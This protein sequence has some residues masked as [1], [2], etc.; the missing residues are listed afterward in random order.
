MALESSEEAFGAASTSGAAFLEKIA[1][2]TATTAGASDD[3]LPIANHLCEGSLMDQTPSASFLGNNQ[4]SQV[5]QDGISSTRQNYLIVFNK[6]DL[7]LFLLQAKEGLPVPCAHLAGGGG[8]AHCRDG[9]QGLD[10]GPRRG[11]GQGGGDEEG[12]GEVEEDEC[13]GEGGVEGEGQGGRQGG[14]GQGGRQHQPEVKA[15]LGWTPKSETSLP[16]FPL[17]LKPVQC[18]V[19]KYVLVFLI[20]VPIFVPIFDPIDSINVLPIPR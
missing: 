12:D 19:P 9:G 16:S 18:P 1:A 4:V 11:D 14:E 13:G 2:T 7:T 6:F 8:L 3:G 10:E 5:A 17:V 20:F 15:G